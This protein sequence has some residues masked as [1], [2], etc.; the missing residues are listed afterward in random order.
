MVRR[1]LQYKANIDRSGVPK[2]KRFLLA[3]QQELASNKIFDKVI[4][5]KQKSKTGKEE[6]A[7]ER[8][9]KNYNHPISS[10]EHNKPQKNCK[11]IHYAFASQ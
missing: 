7:G 8:I 11:N 10:F 3:S 4:Q 6:E 5:F 2:T 1:S 9:I